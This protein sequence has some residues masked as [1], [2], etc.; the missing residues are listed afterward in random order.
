MTKHFCHFERG[1]LRLALALPSEKSLWILEPEFWKPEFGFRLQRDFSSGCDAEGIAK[2]LPR[3]DNEGLLIWTAPH[4]PASPPARCASLLP[5]AR[6]EFM[7]PVAAEGM[8]RSDKG[9][10][11]R[12]CHSERGGLRL[13]LA[14]PSEK[15]LWIPRPEF[16]KPEF[17]FRVQRDFSSPF[18]LVEMTE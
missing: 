12:I 6:L 9:V 17:G 14:Q 8:Q 15:S 7:S 18:G 13:A 3:N 5:F 16:W 2:R 11:R 10:T 4:S 1:G